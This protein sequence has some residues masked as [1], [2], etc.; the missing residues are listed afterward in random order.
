MEWDEIFKSIHIILFRG[1]LSWFKRILDMHINCNPWYRRRYI[2]RQSSCRSISSSIFYSSN[3]TNKSLL[4]SLPTPDCWSFETL[5][6]W[7]L[8]MVN[9]SYYWTQQFLWIPCWEWIIIDSIMITCRAW[10][11]GSSSP[12]RKGWC[13]AF[14]WLH[15]RGFWDALGFRYLQRDTGQSPPHS[16]SDQSTS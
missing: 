11:R 1:I 2:L 14:T 6:K 8:Q 16:E 5:R 10:R 15:W 12:I 4:G 9:F 13:F 7:H 3:K